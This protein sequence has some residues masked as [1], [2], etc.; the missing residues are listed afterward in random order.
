MP[1]DKHTGEFIDLTEA[2]ELTNTYQAAFPTEPKCFFLGSDKIQSV[3][4]QEGCVGIRMYRAFDVVRNEQNV[5]I[6]GVN[7]NGNDMTDGLLLDRAEK[8]PNVC[9]T[10]S[11]LSN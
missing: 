5:V 7:A 6:V 3:I 11:P 8:C 2:K 1:I 4:D 9:D 10:T